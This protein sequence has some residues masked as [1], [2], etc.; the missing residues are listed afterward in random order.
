LM[1]PRVVRNL[2]R[3]NTVRSG[4]SLREKMSTAL[5]YLYS[6]TPGGVFHTSVDL[7]AL[8]SS[9]I[10]DA[11]YMGGVTIGVHR[12]TRN[13]FVKPNNSCWYMYE[14]GW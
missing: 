13:L 3:V 5:L 7:P 11:V 1:I 12:P 2:P 4:R 10:L 9:I 8:R 6:N 14:G